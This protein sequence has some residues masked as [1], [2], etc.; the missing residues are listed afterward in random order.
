MLI[1]SYTE[2]DGNEEQSEPSVILFESLDEQLFSNMMAN[3]VCCHL[4]AYS[5]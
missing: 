2:M 4:G 1:V 5:V 3:Q